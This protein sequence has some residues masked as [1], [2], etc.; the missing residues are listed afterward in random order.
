MR[1]KENSAPH[2]AQRH[3]EWWVM[4]TKETAAAQ[5][6]LRHLQCLRVMPRAFGVG[7]LLHGHQMAI[8][9][10]SKIQ[11]NDIHS[12]INATLNGH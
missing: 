9:G 11:F 8:F 3:S 2:D 5:D 7:G 12:Q 6:A 10:K 1:S 4:A